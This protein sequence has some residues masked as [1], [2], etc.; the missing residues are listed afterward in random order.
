MGPEPFADLVTEVLP[1]GGA[2]L[3]AAP[4]MLDVWAPLDGT[5]PAAPRDWWLDSVSVAEWS[6]RIRHDPAAA[7]TPR[8]PSGLQ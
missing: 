6:R 3:A 8:A 4:R 5:E 2:L 1:R 7:P